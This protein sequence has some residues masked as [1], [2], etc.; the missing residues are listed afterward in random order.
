MAPTLVVLIGNT[1]FATLASA[2]LSGVRTLTVGAVLSS[3]VGTLVPQATP[4]RR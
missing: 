3:L 2:A 1:G 4:G